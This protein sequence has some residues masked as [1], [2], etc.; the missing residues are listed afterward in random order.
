MK[1][2]IRQKMK[3]FIVEYSKNGHWRNAALCM[4]AVVAVLTVYTLILPAITMGR[5][6][7]CGMEEHKHTAECYEKQLV[8]GK[9]ENGEDKAVQK[10]LSC[11]LQLHQHKE[12]CYDNEG[13]I[14]CGYADYVVHQHSENCYDESGTLVC[15]LPEVKA[16]THDASCYTEEKRLICT[17]AETAGHIHTEDCY[18]MVETGNINCIAPEEEGHVHTEECYEKVKTLTCGQEEVP[19][20]VHTDGCYE[21]VRQ[22]VCGKP[23]V[24]LHKHD[25]VHCYSTDENGNRYLSCGMLEVL[26]H[27]HDDKCFREVQTESEGHVHTEKCYENVLICEKTEHTHELSCYPETV[28]TEVNEVNRTIEALPAY[29]ELVT[30]YTSFRAIDTM[31]LIMSTDLADFLT[32]A[33]LKDSQGNVVETGGTLNVG[34]T[35]TV[36]FAFA[37]RPEVRQISGNTVTY[38][39]PAN[40]KCKDFA[41]RQNAVIVNGSGHIY[42]YEV[43]DNQLTVKFQDNIYNEVQDLALS[44]AL[45]AE[46][47]SAGSS[48]RIDI[49]ISDGT[50]IGFDINN[51]PKPTLEK[52]A[53]GYD[54]AARKAKYEIVITASEGTITDLTLAD[55]LDANG[56]LQYNKDSLNLVVTRIDKN[57]VS[58]II[59]NINPQVTSNTLNMSL[60]D[61]NDG[62]MYSITYEAELKEGSLD[63]NGE[64]DTKENN[65]VVL[66]GTGANEFSLDDKATVTINSGMVAKTGG[67]STTDGQD[68]LKWTIRVGDGYENVAGA[69]IRDTLGEGQTI[70]EGTRIRVNVIDAVTKENCGQMIIDWEDVTVSDDKRTIE[71]TLPT[72]AEI[73]AAGI[74]VPEHFYFETYYYA[75]YEMPEGQISGTFENTVTTIIRDKEYETTGTATGKVPLG[76]IEKTVEAKDGYLYYKIEYKNIPYQAGGTPLRIIDYLRFKNAGG[77]SVHYYVENVP[78]NMVVTLDGEVLPKDSGT[79]YYSLRTYE[80]HDSTELNRFYITFNSNPGAYYDESKINVKADS[81]ST[82]TVTYQIPM[83]AL[84]YTDDAYRK[85]ITDEIRVKDENGNQKTI[86]DLIEEGRS[87]NNDGYA[88][89]SGSIYVHDDVDYTDENVQKPIVKSHQ[90]NPDGTITYRVVFENWVGSDFYTPLIKDPST[91]AFRDEFNENMEYVPNSFMVEVYKAQVHTLNATYKY[92]GENPTPNRPNVIE[93]TVNDFNERTAAE[94]WS[95][96]SYITLL[97]GMERRL[98]DDYLG[99]SRSYSLEFV[100]TLRVK[101]DVLDNATASMITLDNHAVIEADEKTYDTTHS[102][103][104]KTGLMDKTAVISEEGSNKVSFTIDLN[105]NCKKLIPPES[106]EETLTLEDTMS[107][108]LSVRVSTIKITAA[109]TDGVSEDITMQTGIVLNGKVLTLSNLPD[110]RHIVITYDADITSTGDNISVSNSAEITSVAGIETTYE[111]EF[112]VHDI[113]SEAIGHK[114]KMTV[115]KKDAETNVPLD[116]AKFAL[117]MVPKNNDSDPRTDSIENPGGVDDIIHTS[118]GLKAYFIGFYVTG[119]SGTGRVEIENQYLLDGYSYILVETKAPNGYMQPE[120]ADART[121]FGYYEA[122]ENPDAAEDILTVSFDGAITIGND[123]YNVELPETGGTGT[124]PYTM[125]GITLIAAAALFYIEGNKKQ[126]K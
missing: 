16:H 22:Y 10:V 12:S 99:S 102:F 98:D 33:I 124:I 18:T 47:T 103:D 57:G 62:E 92:T 36:S 40:L 32:G 38:T 107:E 43:K 72:E 121:E 76:T 115:M 5:D 69:Q 2:S 77:N 23:E 100:Y 120:D 67:M 84:V 101:K 25:E 61:L 6:A 89:H 105:P 11:S 78:Q 15:A 9:E 45:E 94:G 17:A 110:E 26:S 96:G 3:K 29:E 83:T 87:L 91:L 109:D 79:N 52:K 56:V 14:I 50:T 39:I 117:Y 4:A 46:V 70:Y 88:N 82:L 7:H 44:I 122:A 1:T 27:E 113:S 20:Y 80:N 95:S 54:T 55:S 85:N 31:D 21:T 64:I 19:A 48:G 42:T 104:Y 51:D 13:K 35:Y 65:Q 63:A 24:I 93:A 114:G 125:A 73:E 126:K 60:P 53:K 34:A 28:Q 108:N 37:E 118:N 123:A 74:R 86:K 71:Y 30:N 41:P 8:C 49:N 58:S 97:K 112:D 68:K 119:T 59:Q 90:I 66:R 106:I 75:N 111:N 81:T 116:G